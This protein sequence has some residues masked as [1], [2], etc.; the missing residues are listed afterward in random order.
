MRL[1][2]RIFLLLLTWPPASAQP[3]RKGTDCLLVAS[4]K[5]LSVREAT[6]HNDGPEVELVQRLAGARVGIDPWCGCERNYWNLQCGRP[7]PKWPAAAANWSLSTDKR[8]FF[9]LGRR[10]SVDSLKIG[11]TVTFYCANL[12]R[13]GHVGMVVAKGRP[14]RAGRAPRYLLVRAGNTGIGGGR[15]GAGDHDVLYQPASIYAGAIW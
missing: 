10:G 2:Y 11:D 12:G 6:G 8:T 3:V 4:A 14:L 5:R 15:D 7:C 13:V 9:I 1:L